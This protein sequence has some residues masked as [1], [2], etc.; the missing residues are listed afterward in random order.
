MKVLYFVRDHFLLI[1]LWVLLVVSLTLVIF[2]SFSHDF[3]SSYLPIFLP[4][5][6]RDAGI[7]MLVG[8]LIMY[9]FKLFTYGR[10]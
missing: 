9:V 4:D 8:T 1:L 2:P 3:L 10:G 6:P 5:D 7:K